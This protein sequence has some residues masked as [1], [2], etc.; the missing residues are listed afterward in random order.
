MLS[1]PRDGSCAEAHMSG[2]SLT[3]VQDHVLLRELT[4][5]TAKD[6]ATTAV[7]LAHIAEVD[8][9]RLYASAGFSAMFH[10]CV[11]K[12]G[13][14]EDL[15]SKRIRVARVARR[16]PSVFAAIAEGRLHVSG[17][18]VLAATLRNLQAKEA[19]EL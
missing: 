8:T 1:C 6:R 10:Y 17:V 9:R 19:L 11:R 3:H 2:C 18:S 16:F 15:A 7:L 13:F 14:S 5:L 4:A 12:L